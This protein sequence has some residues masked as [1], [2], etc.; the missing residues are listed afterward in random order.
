MPCR[1]GAGAMMRWLVAVLSISAAP[2]GWAFAQVPG[3]IPK[4]ILL[5]QSAAFSGPAAQLGIQMNIGAKA[6]FDRVNFQGGVYGRRI[7]LRTRDDKYESELAAENTKKFIEEDRVFPLFAYVGTPTT[8]A[9]R[10][11]F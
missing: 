10:P 2:F 4:S 6:Y 9:A 7:E 1:S 5:G 3:V 8:L 11:L